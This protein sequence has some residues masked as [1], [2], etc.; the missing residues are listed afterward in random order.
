MT[1]R[2]EVLRTLVDEYGWTRGVEIGVFCGS[3]A[4][5]SA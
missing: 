2:W 4:R 1:E 5:L 3:S